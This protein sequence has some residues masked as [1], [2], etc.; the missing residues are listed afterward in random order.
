MTN[1]NLIA[2]VEP[3][4]STKYSKVLHDGVI[5]PVEFYESVL[6]LVKEAVPF[7]Q[8]DIRYKSSDLC[9]SSFWIPLT[10]A[11]KIDAGACVD[12]IV[13]L[14][15]VPLFKIKHRHEYPFYYGLL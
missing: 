5:V 12:D 6:E 10:Q 3:N 14:R 13:F 7:L 11:Q 4:D 15:L 2:P 1:T 8:K 9:G